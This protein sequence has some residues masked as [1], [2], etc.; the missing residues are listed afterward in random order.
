MTPIVCTLAN[1]SPFHVP[2]ARPLSKLVSGT[3]GKDRILCSFTK[4]MNFSILSTIAHI[5][6]L[7]HTLTPHIFT[8]SCL[9]STSTQQLAVFT[10][11]ASMLKIF[12]TLS[13]SLF[14][15]CSQ[16]VPTFVNPSMNWQRNI[17]LSCPDINK[18]RRS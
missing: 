18:K 7:Y 13:T 14:Q 6:W 12:H 15:S 11:L 2:S 17:H 10:I 8:Y 4:I 3:L 16:A 9:H 1:Q 5:S